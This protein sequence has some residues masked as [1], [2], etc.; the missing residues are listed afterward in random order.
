MLQALTIYGIIAGAWNI[1]AGFTRLNMSKQIRARDASVPAEFEGISGLVI[2]AII[3]V[4][5]GGVI[6]VIFVAF[7]VFVRDK[8]LKHRDLFDRVVEKMDPYALKKARREAR[9]QGN[10]RGE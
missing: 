1:F 7:D 9:L 8:V 2:I 3:N 10:N 5:L 4:L 6:G